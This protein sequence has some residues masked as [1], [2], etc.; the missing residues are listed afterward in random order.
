MQKRVI[1]YPNC[2]KG[3]TLEKS[4]DILFIIEEYIDIMAEYTSLVTKP[5]PFLSIVLKSFS[6]KKKFSKSVQ[7]R[8]LFSNSKPRFT[9]NKKMSFIP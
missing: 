7:I 3:L 8:K 9:A 6:N 4:A 2:I 1:F 5:S